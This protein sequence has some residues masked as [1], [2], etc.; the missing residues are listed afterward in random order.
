[1][2]MEEPTSKTADQQKIEQ[3]EREIKRLHRKVKNMQDI[4]VRSL[5]FA[6]GKSAIDELLATEKLKQDRHMRMLLEN[7]QEIIFFFDHIGRLSYC[8][9]SF[10]KLAGIKGFGQISGLSYKDITFNESLKNWLYSV[11]KPFLEAAANKMAFS[12]SAR[13]DLEEPGVYRSYEAHFSPMLDAQDNLEGGI[14]LLHDITE[15]LNA[16]ERAEQ[17]S[18]AKSDFL[19]NISHEIRTPMNAIIGMSQIAQNAQDIIKIKECIE[20]IGNASSHLLSLIND[21]LDF[22]KIESGNLE[23]SNDAFELSVAMHEVINLIYQRCHEKS[24][25]FTTNIESLPNLVIAGDKLRLKQVLINLLGNAVKFTNH[26]GTIQFMVDI[27]EQEAQEI[28]LRFSVRDNG[29]GIV[30][31]QI[32][33]LFNAFEQGDKSISVK[34]GGTGLG[35]AIC[36]KI[37]KAM[38]GTITVESVL[39][40]GSAFSFAIKVKRAYLPKTLPNRNR[41]AENLNLRGKHML[42]VD[43]VEINRTIL[44]ELLADTKVQVE[45]AADGKQALQMVAQSALGY[46]D[47]IFMDI[48]MPNLDGYQTTDAI[49]QLER[50]DVKKLPIIAMTA[51]A[52]QED[53]KRAM[54]AGMNGHLAKPIDIEA[55]RELLYDKLNAR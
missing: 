16:K 8:T 3:M 49:R 35:L 52:Y 13:L 48:Q 51:N 21:V 15:L 29:I 20:Q 22:S 5:E 6:K 39:H 50:S 12:V 7:S 41:G 42:V 46:Y 33:N 30:E 55:V 1:M 2:N 47:I 24:I 37:V 26:Y 17:A 31:E 9:D 44:T 19:S 53:V 28:S 38:G 25:D 11:V 27:Y 40:H 4:Q 54:E 14:M 23:L 34:Y 45:E 10:L 36:Q 32:P 43:D 18:I